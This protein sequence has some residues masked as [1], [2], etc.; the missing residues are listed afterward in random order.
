MPRRCSRQGQG[1]KTAARWGPRT[2]PPPRLLCAAQ[3]ALSLVMGQGIAKTGS[4]TVGV[5]IIGVEPQAEKDFSDLPKKIV[6]GAY[7]EES[8]KRKIVI[9]S[10]LAQRLKVKVGKKLVLATNTIN[11]DL[12]EELFRVKGIYK[13]GSPELDG[14]LAHIPIA[15][16]KKFFGLKRAGNS[17]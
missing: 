10:K 6:T 3:G 17:R 15:K 5:M 4:S 12:S 2:G 1:G 7:L 14:H 13:T 16:A 8:D 11:G 9:G